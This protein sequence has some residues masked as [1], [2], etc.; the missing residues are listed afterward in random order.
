M[1][2]TY[3]AMKACMLNFVRQPINY[4]S[5]TFMQ[6]ANILRTFKIAIVPSLILLCVVNAAHAIDL[7][8]GGKETVKDTFG[9]DSAIAGWLV[10]AEVICGVIAYIKTKNIFLLFGFAVV[11]VFTTVGFGITG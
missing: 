7:L 9:A 8:E 4:G 11:I 6:R 10:L 2:I 1:K 5:I 3:K